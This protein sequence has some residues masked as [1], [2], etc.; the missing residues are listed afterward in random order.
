M[1]RRQVLVAVLAIAALT[2]GATAQAPQGGRG[3]GRGGARQAV[4]RIHQLTPALSM[5]SGGASALV[6]V[7]PEG[8]TVDRLTKKS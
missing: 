5:A 4:E 7:I 1:L 6:R 8:L 3:G 2:V